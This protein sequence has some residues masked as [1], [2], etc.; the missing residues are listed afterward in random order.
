MSN[1]SQSIVRALLVDAKLNL[2]SAAGRNMT[3]G[4]GTEDQQA[5]S[6][7]LSYEVFRNDFRDGWCE[8]CMGRRWEIRVMKKL[9]F[10]EYCSECG[11]RLGPDREHAPDC[12]K[13]FYP[14]STIRY[15]SSNGQQSWQTREEVGC[16]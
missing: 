2:P 5:T 4:F 16:R 12:H 7:L 11:F 1:Q 13:V 14:V 9:R 6:C 15:H 10:M 3:K 8:F